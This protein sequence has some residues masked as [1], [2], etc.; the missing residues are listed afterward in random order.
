M[1]RQL[2]FAA[3]L[4]SIIT[5]PIRAQEKANLLIRPDLTFLSD[6]STGLNLEGA[7]QI[8]DEDTETAAQISLS[9]NE[10]A[11]LV[12]SFSGATVTPTSL[13]V[14]ITGLDRDQASIEILVSEESPDAGFL[15]LRTEPIKSRGNWQKFD[16][17]AA[18]AKWIM[19]K[20]APY[21]APVDFALN[22]LEIEGHDGSPVSLYAFDEAPSDAIDV[23]KGLEQVDLTLDIHPD[24]Q[25]LLDDAQ[26]GKLDDVS[27]AEASLISSGVL[28]PNERA[29]LLEQLD[30]LTTGARSITENK[31]DAFEKGRALLEWLHAGAMDKGYV[32]A[33]T[34]MSVVLRDKQFNCVSSATLYNIIGRRLGLDARGIEV[35]DHAFTILYDGTDHVDV[36]T[37]TP[38]GFD[39]TRDRAALNAF[40]RTTGYNYI[41][42]KHRA[43]RRELDD[44]GMVAL[45]YYNQGVTAT[46]NEDFANALLYYFRALSLDP[47]NKSAIKNTLF[48]LS[49]WSLKT[50]DDEDYLSAVRILDAALSFAPTDRGSRHNM[51][52]ALSKAMV[53]AKSVEETS[54]L[55]AIAEDIYNRTEDKTFLRLQSQALQNKAWEFADKGKYEEALVLIESYDVDQDDRTKRDI[56]R[57]RISLLLN[58]SSAVF[59]AND[60]AKAID[61][62][63][64]AYAERPTDHRVKNNIAFTAQEWAAA[65]SE[66]GKTERSQE[67][68]LELSKRFP[69]I[70]RLQRVS[71]RNYDID[72]RAAFDAG[73]FESAIE[74]YQSAQKL[75]VNKSTMSQNEKI[76]WNK[77]GLS[78]MDQGD[79]PGA[80]AVFERALAAFPRYSKYTNNVA[81]VVQEWGQSFADSGNIVEAERTISVQGKRFSDISKIARMQGNFLGRELENSRS[82]E[83]FEA[84]A[85]SLKSVSTLIEK[86]HKLDQL[87]GVF[88]QNW[89][90]TAD[91]DLAAEEAYSILQSGIDSYPENRHVKKLFVYSAN[92]LGD[93]A[94]NDSDWEQ[95]VSV[96]QSASRSLPNERTFK[97]KLEQA[98]ERL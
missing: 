34:N 87:V 75:G 27:F 35:P 21:A 38:R 80:L 57:L 90:K 7:L 61:I 68:L 72:A 82:S 5:S 69:E 77:W 28:D 92:R 29:A 98:R 60:H 93:E 48:V 85:P 52:Y 81:Y 64:R 54:N 31:S 10:Q 23:L 71:A 11:E 91:P 50:I 36:E 44:A 86:K 13:K 51:R 56:E 96:F 16:F 84:L 18:A 66:S 20:I 3:L 30:T 37:T 67:V 4:L 17:E 62:L 70:R 78:R 25:A 95:A 24:E 79:F 8:K 65:L 73:N 1:N 45:T 58:W 46:K 89:A 19:V 49:K 63:A 47:R 14:F 97:R 59:D 39:P 15:S 55:V 26:D 88:Y 94:M 40:S 83:D 9:E 53:A 43:K 32:E 33:Q 76:V 6:K 41:S 42:D 22:E 74:I 12:F 2:L